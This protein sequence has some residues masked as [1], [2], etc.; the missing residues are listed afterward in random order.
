MFK[1]LTVIIDKSQFL[2]LII[3]DVKTALKLS[4]NKSTTNK[5]YFKQQ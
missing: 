4:I 2:H 5:I 1:Q 3:M